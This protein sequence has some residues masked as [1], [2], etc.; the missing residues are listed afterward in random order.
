MLDELTAARA[1]YNASGG[2]K[3]AEIRA[4]YVKLPDWAVRV[5]DA[6]PFAPTALVAKA[7]Y[8]VTT[9]RTLKERM[10][11]LGTKIE[12]RGEGE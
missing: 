7:T 5:I 3:Y 11:V 12:G 4:I 6:G 1:K 10:Q 9:S 2:A 8:L